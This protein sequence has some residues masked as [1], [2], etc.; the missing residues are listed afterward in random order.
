L[1]SST[2]G[3]LLFSDVK[4]EN[5]NG[6]TTGKIWKFDYANGVTTFIEGAGLVGPGAAPENLAQWAEAGPN[7]LVW[8]WAGETE[9]LFAQHGKKRIA[10]VNVADVSQGSVSSESV[11][12]VADTFNGS[13]LNS[14]NDMTMVNGTLLFTDPPYGLQMRGD[15]GLDPA[16]GR[17]TQP[18]TGVYAITESGGQP[19]LVLENVHRPNGIAVSSANHLFV[20]NT[21][22]DAPAVSVFNSVS[23]SLTEFGSMPAHM[24]NMTHRIDSAFRPAASGFPPLTD[25]LTSYEGIVFAAGPGGIY[26]LDGT[27]GEKLGLLRVDDLVSNSAVGGGYLWITANQR[28]LRIKL[29]DSTP[30]S[31][32]FSGPIDVV[33]DVGDAPFAWLESP[34]WSSTGGYLLF[35]DVKWENENGETTGKIWKFDYANGVTTFIEGA[36]LVGPGAAPENL[37]QW[38]EAGPNGLVWGWAGE[39]ELLFAQHG[40]KRIAKVNVADV[41]QGS[42]SSESVVVVAD[43]F[44]GSALNSPNDMTMVNGTLL[45]TDPPYGLQMRGDAGLDPAYGRMTQ[46][47][48]GVYAITESGGQPQ[49][50]VEGAHRPNGIAVS[51]SNKLFISITDFDAPGVSMYSASAGVTRIDEG[52]LTRLQTP[53]LVDTAY[54]PA[55]AGFPPLNDGLTAYEDVVFAAGPGGIYVLHGSSGAVLEHLQLYDL[56]SN[57]AVGD[58]YLWITAN[59]RLLRIKLRSNSEGSETTA[60]PNESSAATNTASMETTTASVSASACKSLMQLYSWLFLLVWVLI[61]K[62]LF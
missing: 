17:M 54:R 36:G 56:A 18:R 61:R 37:A 19:Q 40:K 45:F 14:P 25:G 33:A 24:T 21:D 31:S 27:T 57:A 62:D 5:E 34:L 20:A 39:T 44:N 38:A 46:P 55:A 23:G 4:W 11:V 51:S 35:S 3:Y 12:V 30:G 10:K 26:V 9:L 47:R 53:F 13:A 29:R 48:T 41:S 43:T 32:F 59:R 42:V 1:W 49:L 2:G 28:L 15:A 58:G 52:S 8:G 7:G 6:E 50:V 22:F 16:Y 60:G